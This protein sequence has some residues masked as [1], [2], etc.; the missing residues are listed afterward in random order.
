[1]TYTVYFTDDANTDIDEIL[2]Y[3]ARDSIETALEFIAQLQQR[4]D[5]TLSVMPK[6]GR[7]Y[8]DARYFSFGNYIVLYD[9]DDNLNNVY[10]LMVVERHRRWQNLFDN[11]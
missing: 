11:R 10:I 8:S 7:K 9:I 3:I 6:S 4:I 1:M 5:N 2:D